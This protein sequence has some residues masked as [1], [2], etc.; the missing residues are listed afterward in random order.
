MI[1]KDKIE[2][3]NFLARKKKAE[4]LTTEELEEQQSLRAEYL[5]AVR[6]N[7]K[8]Q[9]DSIEIMSPDYEE[10]YT[11]EDKTH[12]AEMNEKLAVEYEDVKRKERMSVT[13]AGNPRKPQGEAGKMMI[14]RMNE[15]HAEMTAWALDKLDLKPTDK[16]LDVGCGGGAAL[17]R[18][19][20]RIDGGKL[21]GIDYSEVSVEASKELNKA[22]IERGKMEIHQGSVSKMPFE[23]N[24]FD[25]IITVESYYFWPDLEEDMRE[26]FR[27][28]KEG[29]TFML[30][31]EMYLND[32]LD[33]H[34][35]E[36]AK[37]FEL[38]NLTVDEFKALFEKVGYKETKIHLKDGKYWICVEGKK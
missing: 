24:L 19:S 15:S 25:A 28:L 10:S 5:E 38:R 27:V 34:H 17:K 12:I 23:D 7:L 22:D 29:G 33:E 9:L 13:E 8:S 30:I 4:G 2:R 3:I 14:E 1:N 36:M 11:E 26:V 35:I 21:Y 6:A 31:A 18:L 37:K 16:V 32:D 20:G